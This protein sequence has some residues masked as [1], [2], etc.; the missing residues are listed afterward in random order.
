MG[1]LKKLF[2]VLGFWSLILSILPIFLFILSLVSDIINLKIDSFVVPCL[3]I[4]LTFP[5]IALG[6]SISG[7]IKDK[8]KTLAIISLIISVLTI[9]FLIFFLFYG[10]LSGS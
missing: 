6:F 10:F 3:V 2:Q 5:Y 4:I 8:S 7:L 9:P 1:R